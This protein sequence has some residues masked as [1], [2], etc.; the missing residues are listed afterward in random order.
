MLPSNSEILRAAG[1]ASDSIVESAQGS[2]EYSLVIGE[3]YVN[4]LNPDVERC[5][6][7]FRNQVDSS[8]GLLAVKDSIERPDRQWRYRPKER[9]LLKPS[10]R[11]WGVRGPLGFVT[12]RRAR[13]HESLER[14]IEL[15]DPNNADSIVIVRSILFGRYAVKLDIAKPDYDRTCSSE[16][17]FSLIRQPHLVELDPIIHYLRRGIGGSIFLPPAEAYDFPQAV[18][19]QQVKLGAKA[20]LANKWAEQNRIASGVV[21]ELLIQA[22]LQADIAPEDAITPKVYN[23]LVVPYM[24]QTTIA[25]N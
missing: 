10:A 23:A 19:E 5:E 14:G 12:G 3:N 21:A 16:Y 13:L 24:E 1:R 18:S 17:G 20:A 25:N 15:P 7:A 11:V 8:L 4:P 2:K 6:Q 22:S 9:D